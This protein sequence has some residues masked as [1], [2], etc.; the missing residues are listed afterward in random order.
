M[1]VGGLERPC[2]SGRDQ[3]HP[4]IVQGEVPEH[5]RGDV[6]GEHIKEHDET[7]CL[8]VGSETP[9]EQPYVSLHHRHRDPG[10]LLPPNVHTIRLVCLQPLESL[11]AHLLL[12]NQDDLWQL[13][14]DVGARA[15]G[16]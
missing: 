4:E 8:A 7:V 11:L 10:F 13:L 15:Y 5:R 1:R 16:C 9:S 6:R 14:L 3:T 2:H 12:A